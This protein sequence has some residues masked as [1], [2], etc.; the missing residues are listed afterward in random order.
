MFSLN[1]FYRWFLISSCQIVLEN[2]NT[3]KHD[4][5][6]KWI[7]FGKTIAIFIQLNNISQLF[8]INV[9][10]IFFYSSS[11]TN[12]CTNIRI[13]SWV[14][15]IFPKDLFRVLYFYSIFYFYVITRY[16]HVSI[17]FC[18]YCSFFISQMMFT[19]ISMKP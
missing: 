6:T 7:V 2:R 16:F 18:V 14:S 8:A 13:F 10:F 1:C 9:V 15:R 3:P 11:S 4:F 19:F 12:T 17:F 5:Q